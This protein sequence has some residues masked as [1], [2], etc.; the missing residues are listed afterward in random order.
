MT[1]RSWEYFAARHGAALGRRFRRVDRR[2]MDALVRYDWPGNVRELENLVERAA[3]LSEGE[4]LVVD[5]SALES[6]A[7]AASDH[8]PS[9]LRDQER[10][11]IEDALRRTRGRVSGRNGAAALLDL[12]ST[13]LESKIRKLKIDKHRFRGARDA[14]HGNA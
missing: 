7:A 10:H 12:P 4:R 8:R 6:G 9:S 3:I 11:A 14:R 5:V 13:T 2:T 1:S